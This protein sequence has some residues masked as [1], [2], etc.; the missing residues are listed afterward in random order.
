MKN[1]LI[2]ILDIKKNKY[3]LLRHSVK[4]RTY[5]YLIVNRQGNLSINKNRAWHVKK[6]KSQ[7]IKKGAKLLEEL[8]TFQHLTASCSAKSPIKKINIKIR[9]LNDTFKINF[10]LNPFF[11]IK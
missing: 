7:S 10:V 1:K 8:I 11:K 4:L 5:E 3:F 6:N 9:K 2:S